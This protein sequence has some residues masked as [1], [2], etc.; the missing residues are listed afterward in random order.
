MKNKNGSRVLELDQNEQIISNMRQSSADPI[1]IFGHIIE[2]RCTIC[3]KILD[4]LDHAQFFPEDD[5]IVCDVCL[6]N[7][8]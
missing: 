6:N 2:N 4:R 8:P 3:G 7:H 5:S 1:M